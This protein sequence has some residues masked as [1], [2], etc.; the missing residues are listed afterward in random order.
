MKGC[1]PAAACV[2]DPQTPATTTLTSTSP[3]P[4][5]GTSAWTTSI[6]PGD[7][8]A[9]RMV[10][11]GGGCGV[12]TLVLSSTDEGWRGDVSDVSPPA[13]IRLPPRQRASAAGL[14]H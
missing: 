1:R 2:S 9:R 7:T 10:P 6:P 8:T 13:R 3:G 5:R 14:V 12:V 4:G 11:D